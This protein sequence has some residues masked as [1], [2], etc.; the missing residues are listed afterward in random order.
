M[1]QTIVNMMLVII[2]A[3]VSVQFQG[4]CDCRSHEAI[5]RPKCSLQQLGIACR[6]CNLRY[7]V[8]YLST[9][10]LFCTF[11]CRSIYLPM[12]LSVCLSVRPSICPS[13]HLSVYLSVRP[14]ICLSITYLSIDQSNYL[15][16]Y[17]STIYL[18]A[19]LP[20]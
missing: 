7:L 18:S 12:D 5:W 10:H 1:P 4:F 2:Q 17:P 8:I 13:I 14:S 6:E 16:I 15:S 11:V 3:F 9:I 20:I 19:H